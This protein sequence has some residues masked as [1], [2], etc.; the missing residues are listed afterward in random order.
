MC[1]QEGERRLILTWER[2]GNGM[3]TMYGSGRFEMHAELYWG[4]KE[5]NILRII[6]KIYVW[7]QYGGLGRMKYLVEVWRDL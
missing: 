3:G 7:E 4:S 1:M 5:E 6:L 2:D